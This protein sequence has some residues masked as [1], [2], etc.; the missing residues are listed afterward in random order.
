[1]DSSPPDFSHLRLIQPRER[2][3]EKGD[4]SPSAMLALME[5]ERELHEFEQAALVPDWLAKYARQEE[6]LRAAIETNQAFS[7]AIDLA[8]GH[9]S[10]IEALQRSHGPDAPFAQFQ[11]LREAEDRFQA[12][13]DMTRRYERFETLGSLGIASQAIDRDAPK[14]SIPD[15]MVEGPRTA[16]QAIK[17]AV[18]EAMREA[19][20]ATNLPP[21]KHE[22]LSTTPCSPA[23]EP[24]TKPPAG[25]T[26][27]TTTTPSADRSCD[28]RLSR[29]S[30]TEAPP[31]DRDRGIISYISCTMNNALRIDGV[32][33]RRTL[34]DEYTLSFP[35]KE[36]R[37]G[38]EH[39][40]FKP[41]NEAMRQEFLRQILVALGRDR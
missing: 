18:Q 12:L 17:D 13:L 1:M 10:V 4:E 36:G 41:I 26:P 8:L 28:F 19:Q 15:W 23:V 40:Y 38:D 11:T 37:G 2:G 29:V 16:R 39:F 27:P 3:N 7:S 22:R 31:A 14:I 5:R 24:T 35:K 6:R 33:L 21:P 25:K 30:E 34:K 9:S 20:P 32:A